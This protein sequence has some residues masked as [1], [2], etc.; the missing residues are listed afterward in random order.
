MPV[1]NG[2][3]PG[4]SNPGQPPRGVA[5]ARSDEPGGLW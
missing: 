3:A 4:R 1:A 5:K 2:P